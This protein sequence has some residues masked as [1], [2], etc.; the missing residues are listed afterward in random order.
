VANLKLKLGEYATINE[1][2]ATELL[3]GF[4][5]GFKLGYTG[6]REFKKSNNLIS[7]KEN[8]KEV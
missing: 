7:A 6:P 1:A 3:E 4:S 8:T 5:N 2:H